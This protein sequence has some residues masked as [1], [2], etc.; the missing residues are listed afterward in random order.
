MVGIRL[1]ASGEMYKGPRNTIRARGDLRGWLRGAEGYYGGEVAEGEVKVAERGANGGGSA[2]RSQAKNRRRASGG[3]GRR[4]GRGAGGKLCRG[5]RSV[6]GERGAA[7][8]FG[9]RGR[10]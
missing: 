8:L 7:E 2:T 10:V 4:A 5:V 1:Q 3:A 6:R 9:G